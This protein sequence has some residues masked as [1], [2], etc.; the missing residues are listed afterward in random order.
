[1]PASA[2]M[3]TDHQRHNYLRH[4]GLD[5]ESTNIIESWI[6]TFAGMIKLLV[7][8]VAQTSHYMLAM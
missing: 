6:P 2:G 1:M 4:S 8:L 7:L 5:P 3:T